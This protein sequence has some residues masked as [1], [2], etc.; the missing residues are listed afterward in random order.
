MKV[1]VLFAAALAALLFVP[2][3]AQQA[4]APAA[5]AEAD[6]AP[7]HIY[8]RSGLKTHGAGQHDYPQFLADWSKLL[9]E[10]GAIVDGG[11]HFPTPKE[12][13]GIDVIVSYKGDSGFMTE[14]E[15]ATLESYLIRGGGLVAFHDTICAD[16]PAWFST[17]YGGA[18]HHGEVNYTLEA[19]VPYTVVDKA[20]P[21]MAGIPDF[22]IHDEAFF[23]MT[24]SQQPKIHV[25]ATAVIDKTPSAGSHAGEVVPQIWTYE[26]RYSQMRSVAPYRAFVWMQGHEY[27]NFSNPNVQKMLLR[28]IAWAGKRPVDF[29]ENGHPAGRMGGGGGRGRG[30]GRGGQTGAPARGGGM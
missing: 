22:A 15:K 14:D 6:I 13:E 5:S 24:W 8:I 26:R 17:I 19:N 10:K 21:I 16:D 29:L 9:T 25:L 28:G 1:R 30:M 27:A 7:L 18:K 11:L 4:P 12:L 23:L 2:L 3:A 20:S